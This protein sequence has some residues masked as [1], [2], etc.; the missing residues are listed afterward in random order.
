M[1]KEQKIYFLQ[2]ARFFA[3]LS[4]VY[5]H[6]Y[7]VIATP[8]E[9][10]HFILQDALPNY[11][12]I[13][14]PDYVGMFTSLIGL[15]YFSCVYFGLGLFFILSGYVIPLSLRKSTPFDYL[16]RRIYRIYPTLIVCLGLTLCTMTLAGWYL[17][18]HEPNKLFSLQTLLGNMF[19]IRDLVHGRYID[20]ATWTLEIEIH[21]Y[22]LFF[23]FFYFSIE[24]KVTSFLICACSFWVLAYLL[25][26]VFAENLLML[27][28]AVFFARNGSY[29]TFMF[30]GTALYYILSRQWDIS[31]GVISIILLMW[32]SYLCL[33]IN[34]KN[35]GL[36][37]FIFINHAYALLFFTLLYFTNKY[38]PYNRLVNKLAEISY[39]LYLTHGFT[40]Y[41]FYFLFYHFSS[42]VLFS[43]VAALSLV[44]LLTVLIHRYVEKPAIAFSKELIK[45]KENLRLPV[46]L[47]RRFV[48]L[49]EG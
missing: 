19:L 44:L 20:N 5:V 2:I 41:T 46:F 26:Y 25:V 9:I 22:L 18:S 32:V 34:P 27:K 1:E 30:V 45:N 21:F 16:F 15:K 24:K 23:L 11:P 6:W 12:D 10:H 37:Q 8:N 29:L 43:A 28:V 7:G 48:K 38:L 47:K 31:Q 17:D 14:L 40:G 3:C 13:N 36:Y 33:S 4:V 49:N 35:A 42:N 39:P